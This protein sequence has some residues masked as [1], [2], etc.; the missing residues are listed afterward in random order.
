[1]ISDIGGDNERIAHLVRTLLAHQIEG[2][3]Y[4]AD[5]HMSVTLPESARNGPL[6]LVNAFDDINTRCVLPDDEHGQ[7]A[8]TAALLAHGHR[9]IGFFRPQTLR[10][11]TDFGWRATSVRCVR[12]V[13]LSTLRLLWTRTAGVSRASAN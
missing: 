11:R 9:R 12:Q 7:H 6:V 8:L 2:L 13:S 5:H 3:F 4:V 10:S 1:M